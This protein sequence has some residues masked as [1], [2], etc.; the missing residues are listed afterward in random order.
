[1]RNLRGRGAVRWKSI[2]VLSIVLCLSYTG[3]LTGLHRLGAADER[4]TEKAAAG[5]PGEGDESGENSP[6]ATVDSGT[7]E[8]VDATEASGSISESHGGGHLD[9]VSEI[10]LAITVILLAAKLAGDLFER[11]QQ[12]WKIKIAPQNPL[13][14]A[15]KCESRLQKSSSCN[16]MFY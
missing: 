1:M 11:I 13:A 16:P 2:L 6:T 7:V 9:P 8:V 3:Q 15:G 5:S 12:V 4:V 10:L 14:V